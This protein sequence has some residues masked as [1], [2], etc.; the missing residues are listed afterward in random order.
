MD[1]NKTISEAPSADLTVVLSFA[2][3]LLITNDKTLN[4]H[5]YD[6]AIWNTLGG[7][8]QLKRDMHVG[9]LVQSCC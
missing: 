4:L 7:K 3:M 9:C 5:K 1:Y 6:C 8:T 2:A